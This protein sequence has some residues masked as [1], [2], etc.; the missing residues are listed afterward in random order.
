[1]YNNK[2]QG[3]IPLI[4]N[5]GVQHN[6]T[7]SVLADIENATFYALVELD[8]EPVAPA[9]TPSVDADIYVKWTIA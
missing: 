2:V 3:F 9:A 6:F 4:D 5:D 1:M 7:V 8:G